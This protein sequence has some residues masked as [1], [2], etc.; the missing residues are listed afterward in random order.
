MK[1][2]KIQT[3]PIMR[4][5]AI[6][7]VA[8]SVVLTA[9]AGSTALVGFPVPDN[10]LAHF[11]GRI[12]ASAGLLK[13]IAVTLSTS[14]DAATAA[15]VHGVTSGQPVYVVG[16]SQPG[17]F[18]A[19]TLYYANAATT[20][21]LKFYD[22]QAHAVSGGATGLV[23]ITSAGT[24]VVVYCVPIVAFYEVGAVVANRNGNTALVGSV[25]AVAFE[26]VAA[27]AGSVSADDSGN[28]LSLLGTPDAVLDTTIEHYGELLVDS[29][30]A[31]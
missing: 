15:A 4:S 16:S 11:R 19:A 6:S 8:G 25:D 20:T 31:A 24:A 12:K 10:S 17:G 9:N 5:A 1:N 18:T 26:D 30:M 27:W 14:T 7:I 3:P 29:I 28:A 22:T 21:T 2:L 23:D 13:N